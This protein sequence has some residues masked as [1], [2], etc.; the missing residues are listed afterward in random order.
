MK[1]N[2]QNQL[3][4]SNEIEWQSLTEIAEDNVK[5]VYVKS[6]MF[7]KETQRSPT[8]LLKLHRPRH[9]LGA[10]WVRIVLPFLNRLCSVLRF[11]FPP[12]E[13]G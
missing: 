11:Y 4:R 1:Q 6:L 10:G 12:Q 3:V 2:N 8:I 9:R 5:G 7:D 13:R